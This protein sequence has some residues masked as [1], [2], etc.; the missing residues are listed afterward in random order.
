MKRQ[1]ISIK[2]GRKNT[3]LD[4]IDIKRMTHIT[5]RSVNYKTTLKNMKICFS[6][7]GTDI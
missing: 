5:K 1:E 7:P 2:A 6:K 4:L 3:C